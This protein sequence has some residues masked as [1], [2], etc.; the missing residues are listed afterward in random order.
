[1]CASPHR[2][3]TIRPTSE[4]RTNRHVHQLEKDGTRS[5]EKKCIVSGW[6]DGRAALTRRR[7][8]PR[9]DGGKQP[10]TLG[11]RKGSTGEHAAHCAPPGTGRQ[12]CSSSIRARIVRGPHVVHAGLLHSRTI[13]PLWPPCTR[14]PHHAAHHRQPGPCVANCSCPVYFISIFFLFVERWLRRFA[15]FVFVWSADSSG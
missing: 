12:F 4:E 6:R 2:N 9:R 10:A 15:A 7:R 11:M 8:I 3:R 13:I 1:M 5:A 14:T